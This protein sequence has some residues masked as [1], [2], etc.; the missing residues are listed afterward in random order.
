[1]DEFVPFETIE[2]DRSKGLLIVCDHARSDLPREYGTLGLAYDQL[3]RHIAYDIGARW[4]TQNLAEM[5]GVPA[6]LST[7][8]RLLIDPNR[9]ED[10]PTLVM[11]ISDGALI[12]GNARIGP[13]EVEWRRARFYEPYHLAVA[14]EL[15]AIEHAAGIEAAMILSIHSFTESWRGAWRPWEIAILWDSDPRL[16]DLLIHELRKGETL[17]IGDN[18]PYDGALLNDC[19]YR[20]GTSMGR[21]HALVEIRQDLIADEAG[22]SRW[23]GVLERA[24]KPLMERNDLK[25]RRIYPSRAVAETDALLT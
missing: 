1:M 17:T 4:V 19:M 11:R 9:G 10:D 13:A 20:H 12:D 23:A 25:V 14:D 8:S 15:R 2:G 24:M 18:E 16:P 3:K 21:S 6:V 5:L 22:A 7:Y